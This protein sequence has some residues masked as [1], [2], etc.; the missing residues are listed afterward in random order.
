DFEERMGAYAEQQTAAAQARLE[1]GEYASEAARQS[2]LLE[3]GRTVDDY[4]D[5]RNYIDSVGPEPLENYVP[6]GF[7][8]TQKERTQAA[9]RARREEGIELMDEVMAD[10]DLTIEERNA[11]R[12]SVEKHFQYNS[13]TSRQRDPVTL[14]VLHQGGFPEAIYGTENAVDGRTTSIINHDPSKGIS[15]YSVTF[16]PING[17]FNPESHYSSF[18]KNPSR[19]GDIAWSELDVRSTLGNIWQSLTR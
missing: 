1:T 15:P 8:G 6:E 12:L 19:L 18:L 10:P 13:M 4:V 2:D 9:L 5:A 11:A 14:E 7:V 17:A 16:D 3:A